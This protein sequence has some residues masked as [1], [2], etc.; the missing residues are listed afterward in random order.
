MEQFSEEDLSNYYAFSEGDEV[1]MIRYWRKDLLKDFTVKDGC[2]INSAQFEGEYLSTPYFYYSFLE[3][4]GEYVSGDEDMIIF[5]I[6]KE[7]EEQFPELKGKSKF[8]LY[9]KRGGAVHGIIK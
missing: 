7:E 5:E 4:Y 2:I 9:F 3:G 1:N 6:S 8:Y